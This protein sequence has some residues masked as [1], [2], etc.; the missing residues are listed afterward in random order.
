MNDNAGSNQD[1]AKDAPE[2][3]EA[4]C[5]RCHDDRGLLALVAGGVRWCQH[6]RD[7]WAAMSMYDRIS[8]WHKSD[9]DLDLHEYLG[10]SWKDYSQWVMG[11]KQEFRT[12]A[13]TLDD[14]LLDLVSGF[15]ANVASD[16]HADI[17]ISSDSVRLLQAL[18]FWSDD[19]EK[20]RQLITRRR[21]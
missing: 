9:S 10:L 6:C 4:G 16:P 8:D 14:D 21:Q 3:D 19:R 12:D 15:L 13:G 1:T 2:G 17:H 18:E 11:A 20:S 7:I 5:V